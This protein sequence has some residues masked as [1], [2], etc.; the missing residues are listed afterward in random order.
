MKS[1]WDNDYFCLRGVPDPILL[2]KCHILCHVYNTFTYNL[3]YILTWIYWIMYGSN[4]IDLFA[5]QNVSS[6][7]STVCRLITQ[8][9]Y[10][11]RCY[12]VFFQ[13]MCFKG[14]GV[15]VKSK[16]VW[17]VLTQHV[18]VRYGRAYLFQV[19]PE[20]TATNVVCEC[21]HLSEFSTTHS[22]EN[23]VSVT[24]GNTS[25]DAYKD[26]VPA[27][28]TATWTMWPV[29]LVSLVVIA[30]IKDR[31]HRQRVCIC[32]AIRHKRTFRVQ[33]C[34]SV[35]VTLITYLGWKRKLV[36]ELSL[37]LHL[38]CGIRFLPVFS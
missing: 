26:P 35:Y 21:N 9:T 27:W 15:L 23:L 37:L 4:I 17:A 34:S 29:L 6:Q 7:N 16:A 11:L 19:S 2:F 30:K 25:A 18:R 1:V 28:K 31:M 33:I 5:A 13:C 32:A 20:T 24:H 8:A 10:I 14:F 22:S 38:I 36:P 12:S 3:H